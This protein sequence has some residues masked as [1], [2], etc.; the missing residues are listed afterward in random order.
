MLR[1]ARQTHVAVPRM[2]AVMPGVVQ[3]AGTAIAAPAYA[4]ASTAW[5]PAPAAAAAA[6]LCTLHRPLP[7][8]VAAA[9]TRSALARPSASASATATATV[10]AAPSAPRRTF[11][12]FCN[13]KLGSKERVRDAAAACAMQLVID[14]QPVIGGVSCICAPQSG[15]ELTVRLRLVLSIHFVVRSATAVASSSFPST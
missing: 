10:S 8:A 4:S 5:R 15:T 2:G 1:V 7:L 12:E 11:K 13:A 3:R 9:C 6:S 14:V